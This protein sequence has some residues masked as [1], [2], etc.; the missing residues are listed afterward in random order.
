MINGEVANVTK[1][2][3]ASLPRMRRE[4]AD[5]AVSLANALAAFLEAN[6]NGDAAAMVISSACG[7]RNTYAAACE[8]MALLEC[9]LGRLIPNQ[10]KRV[11]G[12]NG[13]EDCDRSER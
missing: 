3:L 6:G 13:D 9:D 10:I 2:V 12:D 1:A 5:R 8:A 11:I 4:S 7:V